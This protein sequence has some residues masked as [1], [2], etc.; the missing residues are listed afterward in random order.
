MRNLKGWYH[1]LG[2][3]AKHFTVSSEALPHIK[4]QYTICQ[5]MATQNLMA[6]HKLAKDITDGLPASEIFL[7]ES[8]FSGADTN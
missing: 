4:R 3:V 6:L 8:L 2:M 7:D 1:D 5:T